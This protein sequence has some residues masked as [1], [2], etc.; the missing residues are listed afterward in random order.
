MYDTRLDFMY[1]KISLPHILLS[2]WMKVPEFV[3]CMLDK[4]SKSETIDNSTVLPVMKTIYRQLEEEVLSGHPRDLSYGSLRTGINMITRKL[5][6]DQYEEL[7]ARRGI[8]N[9]KKYPDYYGGV[10]FK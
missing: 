2:Q 9:P 8:K 7:M 1:N 10:K 4:V 5:Y 6:P 3:D